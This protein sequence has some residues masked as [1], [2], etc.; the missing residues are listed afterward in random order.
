MV[1]GNGKH[2]QLYDLRLKKSVV[3][4]VKLDW[5]LIQVVNMTRLTDYHIMVSNI[6]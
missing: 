2:L 6:N 4:P 3:N 5:D 1:G